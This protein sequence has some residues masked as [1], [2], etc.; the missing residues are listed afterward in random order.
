MP[1]TLGDTGEKQAIEALIQ[2]FDPEGKFRLGD[3]CAIID[4]GTEYLLVTTDMVNQET[5]IPEGTGGR[6]LG[7]YA[8]A[9]NLS[10]IAGMGGFPLGM[11]FAM[12][13]P[14]DLPTDYLADIS[15]GM[16]DC[17]E[18]NGAR[19]LGGDL[20]E[21]PTISISG[22]AIGLVGKKEIMLRSGARPGDKVFLTG[23]LGNQLAWY[24]SP[25]A[26][27]LEDLLKIDPRLKEG[28]SLAQS[29]V[30]T[31]CIDLS[32]GLSTSLHHLAKAGD[33][34]F[35][36]DMESIPFISGLSDADK[37]KCLHLGGEFE[38]LFTAGP[39][40]ASVL[41]DKVS[42]TPISM[43]GEVIE[44]FGVTIIKDGQRSELEDRGY[45]HFR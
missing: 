19:V 11:L 45:E 31:S 6:L 34:G 29:G 15:M 28:Q 39:R 18:K 41:G 23:R 14:K 43:I 25:D 4:M 33:T 17:C 16:K 2:L 21:S 40:A 13:L 35:E 38:L 32:D 1:K 44:D 7:W 22:T 8:A 20:K 9:I 27:N 37:E 3:D 24:G 26:K 36:I 10:D 30:V 42:G 12:G 5:H